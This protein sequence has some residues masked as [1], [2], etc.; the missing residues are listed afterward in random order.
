MSEKIWL[1]EVMMMYPKKFIVMANIE[2]DKSG[3]NTSIGEIVAVEDTFENALV[4]LEDLDEQGNMGECTIVQGFDDTPQI[5][6]LFI[7]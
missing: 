4:I 7:R 1:Q 3:T 2:Y 5:G 6:G